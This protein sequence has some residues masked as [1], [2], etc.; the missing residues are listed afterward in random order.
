MKTLKIFCLVFL[1]ILFLSC[2]RE[3]LDST[4]EDAPEAI[5]LKLNS[6]G[7]TTFV[8]K[9]ISPTKQGDDNFTTSTNMSSEY[10][11]DFKLYQSLEEFRNDCSDFRSGSNLRATGGI[12]YTGYSA[13]YFAVYLE[14]VEGEDPE[15]S[16]GEDLVDI[17]IKNPS[18]KIIYKDRRLIGDPV[19]FGIATEEPMD[20]IS[21]T[22]VSFDPYGDVITSTNPL[23]GYCDFVMDNDTDGD[24]VPD[25]E[26]LV[27]NSN[28]EETVVIE[29]CDS[30]VEN[31]ALG[32]GYMLSDRIDELEAGDYRNHGHFMKATAHYLN[33]L[34]EEEI[35]TYEEKDMIMSCAGSSSLGK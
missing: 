18:S 13:Y 28:M 27:P 11:S 9:D 21:F 26:D 7:E 30:S 34:V 32:E 15:H 24:G 25:K 22:K 29:E 31:R 10:G 6:D 8:I 19:F 23:F 4:E 3:S 12:G 1:A 16:V 2:E 35:L 20:F 5:Y 14:V 33:S 17:E